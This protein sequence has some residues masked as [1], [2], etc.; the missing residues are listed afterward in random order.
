MGSVVSPIPDEVIYVSLELIF[1]AAFVAPWSIPVLM[2]M[3]AMN[4]PGTIGFELRINNTCTRNKHFR[5]V[6]L[7]SNNVYRANSDF[8]NRQRTKE[9]TKC[10]GKMEQNRVSQC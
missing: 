10:A 5:Y 3:S 8:S 4:L 7:P 6:R 9:S 2:E 1:P